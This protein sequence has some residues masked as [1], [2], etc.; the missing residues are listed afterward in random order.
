MCVAYAQDAT[1][2]DAAVPEVQLWSGREVPDGEILDLDYGGIVFEDPFGVQRT[3]RWDFVRSLTGAHAEEAEPFLRLGRLAWRARTRL[4]RGDAVTAEPIFEELYPVYEGLSSDMA[5][6]V[7]EGLM[8]CRLRRSAQTAAIRPWLAYLVSAQAGP[9]QSRMVGALRP[10]CDQET[11]LVPSLAPVWMKTPAVEVFARSEPIVVWDQSQ[12]IGPKRAE[13]LE[14][15]YRH[16]ARFECGLTIGTPDLSLTKTD[17]ADDGVRLVH[18]I[19][20]A[21]VGD[22]EQRQAARSTLESEMAGTRRESAD[23]AWIEAWCRLGIGRSLLR[24]SDRE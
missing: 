5:S 23:H 10:A 22:A 1:P 6:M 18:A 9:Y 8:R 20:L 21:R 12:D 4:E 19:V 3:V 14:R 16:A 11:G 7:A 24:E 13:I 15:L 17:L 2:D